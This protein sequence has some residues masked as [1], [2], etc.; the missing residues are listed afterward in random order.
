MARVL[1]IYSGTLGSIKTDLEALGHTVTTYTAGFFATVDMDAAWGSGKD[2]I[3]L[4]SLDSS[5]VTTGYGWVKTKWEAGVPVLFGARYGGGYIAVSFG[6]AGAETEIQAAS[7]AGTIANAHPVTAGVSGDVPLSTGTAW[8]SHITSGPRGTVLVNR[9]LPTGTFAV[10]VDKGEALAASTHSPASGTAPARAVYLGWTGRDTTATAQGRTILGNAITWLAPAGPT[11]TPKTAKATLTVTTDTA[12]ALTH[13]SPPKVASAALTVTTDTTGALTF[14]GL[15]AYASATLTVTTN[16]SGAL[17]LPTP[18]LPPGA[19]LTVTTDATGTLDVAAAASAEMAVTTDVTGWLS[20]THVHDPATG[21][22]TF[23]LVC[24]H[25][26][27]RRYAELDGARITSPITSGLNDLDGSASGTSFTV[28]L[29]D[30]KAGRWLRQFREIHIERGGH[31]LDTFVAMRPQERGSHGFNTWQAVGLSW[32]FTKR[33]IGPAVRPE[34]LRNASFERGSTAYWHAGNREGSIPDAP[35]RM[36]IVNDPIVGKKALRVE[37]STHV[38][39]T[40]TRLGSDTTF[41]PGSDVLSDAGK[42]AIRKFAE[43]VEV[44]NDKNDLIDIAPPVITIEGHTDSVPDSGPGGNMGLSER[45]A[46]AVRDFLAPLLPKDEDDLPLATLVVR[47]YGDTR[48]VV[49][50]QPGGTAAN[51]R[52]D[53]IYPKTVSARGHRQFVQ[54]RI[55]YTNPSR[56]IT[57]NLTLVAWGMLESYKEPN[58]DAS[59]IWIGRRPVPNPDQ[60]AVTRGSVSAREWYRLLREK[61]RLRKMTWTDLAGNQQTVDAL[62]PPHPDDTWVEF[63]SVDI[64]EETPLNTATRWET[65]ITVPPDGREWEIVV[66]LTPP[67]GTVIYDAVSLKADDAL[68]FINVDQALIVKALVEHAQDPAFDK[69]DLRLSTDT[70][71]TGVKRTMVFYWHDR[72]KISDALGEVVKLTDGVD[73][74]ID[75]TPTKRTVRTH[76]PR[77][78]RDTGVALAVGSNVDDYALALDGS[79]WATT[80]VVQ[81]DNSGIGREEGVAGHGRPIHVVLEDVYTAEP[82][83][84]PG[85]LQAQADERRYG[86]PIYPGLYRVTCATEHTDRLIDSVDEGDTV[87]LT[88][89]TPLRPDETWARVTKKELDAETDRLM[90]EA[91]AVYVDGLED[92][93]VE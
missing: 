21:R 60:Q 61:W 20:R 48:P 92:E 41:A 82:G 74:T 56:H 49:P 58:A 31:H 51:R 81:S 23:A 8:R 18:D 54:Q 43:E 36:R 78:G 80:V 67:A 7:V 53:I 77:A 25:R 91:E 34:L 93:E 46:K 69:D 33:R 12:G 13:P 37:G 29:S 68:E 57:R 30:T 14:V 17:T 73:I 83:T 19:T 16:V 10:A 71:L 4:Q 28:P 1:V 62:Y 85:Q 63:S 89:G 27:G 3:V 66:R 6:L 47:W 35:P 84:H 64:D 32:Y 39:Q 50:N 86:S 26:H 55:R 40:V 11:P 79:A 65:S 52:V 44:D 75:T 9:T 76:Y 45:R 15:P 42:D 90:F 5:Q 72:W 59:V 70:P 87:R 24:A 22:G 38:Q 2:V 88:L